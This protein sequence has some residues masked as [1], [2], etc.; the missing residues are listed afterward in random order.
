MLPPLFAVNG[1]QACIFINDPIRIYLILYYIRTKSLKTLVNS[2]LSIS[3]ELVLIKDFSKLSNQ[4]N[5]V[6]M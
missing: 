6:A 1:K 5:L 3:L 4:D 2:V